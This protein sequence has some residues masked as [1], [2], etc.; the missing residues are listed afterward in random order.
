MGSRAFRHGIER[1]FARI[2]SFNQVVGVRLRVASTRAS[3]FTC[4]SS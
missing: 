4:I 2:R 3:V 1:L